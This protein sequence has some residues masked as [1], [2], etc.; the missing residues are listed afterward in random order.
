MM[1]ERFLNHYDSKK[2][3]LENFKSE[4]WLIKMNSLIKP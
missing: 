3:K 1:T 2:L 4:Q